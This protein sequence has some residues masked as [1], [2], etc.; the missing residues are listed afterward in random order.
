MLFSLSCRVAEGFLSKEEATLSLPELAALAAGAGYGA[1]C[2]RA[3]QIGVHSPPETVAA[4]RETLDASGL[5]V[6]MISGDFD[7]VHNNDRGPACLRDIEPHLDLAE[8]LGAPL[9]RVALKSGAD[10]AAA[11]EAADRAAGRGLRLVH[12]CHLQSPFETI[13]GILD[14]LERIGRPENFGL[15]YEAANLEQCGQ[16]HGRET[17]ARLAPWIWNV[18]LQNQRLAA[19]GAIGLVSRHAGPVRFDLLEIPETG[20]IDFPEI[21]AG[22][23]EIGY[24]GP[25]TVHQSAPADPSLT[26]AESAARTAAYLRGL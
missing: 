22:L 20:G 16:D 18:Y 21:F 6:T 7:I 26:S 12:Q 17:V 9:I 24:E 2:M 4:A 25:V 13:E 3:S 5:G 14:T 11:R 23:R 8:A 10:I 15:I 19:D 1:I